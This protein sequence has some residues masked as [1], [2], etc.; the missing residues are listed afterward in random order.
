M[1]KKEENNIIEK[2]QK[3]DLGDFALIY[4]IY[5]D[6]IYRYIY[7]KTF[8]KDLTEDLT[9]DAFFKAMDKID[10]FNPSKGNFSSWLYKIALNTVRDYYRTKHESMNVEDFWGV[11]SG[12]DI[13]RK[14]E[15]NYDLSRVKEYMQVLNPEQREIVLLRLW[16]GLSYDEIASIVDKKEQNCRVIFHRTIK[17]MRKDI[18]IA[19]LAIF[20]ISM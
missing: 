4:D 13:N 11:D 8:N 17:T 2:C 19:L 3:G 16:H 14:I 10:T 20:F 6:K 15:N 5:V 9:S 1:N 7:Y 12:D 18:A